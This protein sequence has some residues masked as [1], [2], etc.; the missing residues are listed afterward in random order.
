MSPRRLAELTSP[1]VAAL[2]PHGIAVLPV[3]AVEQHGPHLPLLT[4]LLVAETLAADAV[5]AHGDEHELWLLPPLACTKSNEHAW[6][7]GTLWL[8]AAT[9]MAVVHDLGRSVA[10]TPLR[11]LVFLNGHGGNSALLNVCA[12]EL[13]LD[14]G[15][16][17][18]VMHPSLP[19]DQ[20]GVSPAEELGTGIHGGK[21]ETSLVLHLRPDLVRMDLAT[22]NVPQ[23]LAGFEHV[24]FGGPVSFGWSSDDF[25]T[26]GT[27]GDPTLATAG[28]GAALYAGMLR[29]AG[30]AFAEIARFAHGRP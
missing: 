4:D 29:Q 8:G 6:A 24:R 23:R 1:A 13:R 27:L 7:A 26:D 18:F 25:G 14:F 30:E 10:N 5:A 9:L 20:G 28:H 17:T 15:L 19:P 22:R 12:R 16:A 3:G 11:K 2:P 21:D